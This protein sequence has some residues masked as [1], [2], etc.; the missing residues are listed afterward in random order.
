M[1]TGSLFRRASTA[2]AVGFAAVV[3]VSG[4]LGGFGSHTTGRLSPTW[5]SGPRVDRQTGIVPSAG[6]RGATV[7]SAVSLSIPVGSAPTAVVYDHQDEEIFVANSASLNLTVVSTRND[8]ANASVSLAGQSSISSEVYDSGSDYVYAAGQWIGLCTG[9]MGPWADAVNGT[10]H[11]I[12]KSNTSLEGLDSPDTFDCLGYSLAMNQVYA[13]DQVGRVVV[14]SGIDDTILGYLPAGSKPSAV[15]YDPAVGYLYVANSGSNNITVI[16]PWNGSVVKSIH[17]GSQP[18]ALLVDPDDGYLYAANSASDNVS[19]ILPMYNLVWRAIPVGCG[20]DA[21]TYLHYDQTIFVANQCSDNLTGISEI[22]NEAVSSIPVGTSPVGIASDSSNEQIYV[23]NQGSDNVTAINATVVA[24]AYT[25]TFVASGLPTGSDFDVSI[26]NLVQGNQ[27]NSST[28]G[29]VRF[30]ESDGTY[31]YTVV[32]NSTDL[33]THS[34][35]VVVVNGADVNV[36]VIFRVSVQLWFW[37]NGWPPGPNFWQV[38]VTNTSLGFHASVGTNGN[39]S[40]VRVFEDARYS[41]SVTFPTNYS[42]W[43]TSGNVTVGTETTNVSIPF[44]PASHP[45][46]GSAPFPW[47]WVILGASIAV[48]VAVVALIVRA[49]RRPSPVSPP[50]SPPV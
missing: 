45:S 10:S 8:S 42:R 11:Q 14:L 2:L 39:V 20:P 15:A 37:V 3:V 47:T 41:Y 21:L 43:D 34:T 35:G 26:G 12:A 40:L 27:V 44:S 5:Q 6:E 22:T 50:T 49:R 4:A 28:T 31:N 23:V 33:A 19:I 24:P 17:V 9:C 46:S 29:L 32:T 7:R 18:D 1:A 36:S 16:N 30:I 25:V 48:V 38:N 13:C